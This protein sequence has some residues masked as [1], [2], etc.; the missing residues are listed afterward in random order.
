MRWAAPPTDDDALS[1][2]ANSLAGRTLAE[3]YDNA[4]K[5]EE[6]LALYQEIADIRERVFGK[7]HA[8][9]IT[10]MEFVAHVY[11]AH[12]NRV[13]LAAGIYEDVIE[14][15]RSIGGPADLVAASKSVELANLRH[16]LKQAD[17]RDSVVTVTIAVLEDRYGAT[18]ARV[19]RIRQQAAIRRGF[20]GQPDKGSE[21]LDE[22]IPLQE[23]ALGEYHLD[24]ARSLFAMMRQLLWLE[25]WEEAESAALRTIEVSE[26]IDP[27]GFE[28]AR[29]YTWA[30][31]L[32][33]SWGKYEKAAPLG[34][35]GVRLFVISKGEGSREAA[36]SSSQAGVPL[37]ELG[38]ME[39]ARPYFERYLEFYR[40]QAET[41]PRDRYW[42]LNALIGGQVPREMVDPE[43]AIAVAKRINE[44][45]NYAD[46]GDLGRLGSA[47]AF[48]GR[49]DEAME[50]QGKV[51]V[52]AKQ[53]G[54]DLAGALY[55]LACLH[56]LAEQK[57]AALGSL[58]EAVE[59][60]FENARQAA[61]DSDLES[62]QG[63]PAFEALLSEMRRKQGR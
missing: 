24:V 14:D 26:K 54:G 59:A 10:E 60:G 21:I 9:T 6:S 46:A 55:D 27:L 58:R 16:R 2:R 34:M 41:R 45:S 48:A 8:E 19:L 38:R 25:R 3:H 5:Y 18:D 12:L 28:T 40:K 33:S 17:A 43:E 52:L 51:I 23:Q 1:F 36:W 35:E 11:E 39:E 29:A 15:R 63:D 32:Y 31:I 7:G 22:I 42:F 56:A 57:D 20:W 13:D 50:V 37:V 30:G 61:R 49:F 47:Y 4:D 53:S 44:S 62:L